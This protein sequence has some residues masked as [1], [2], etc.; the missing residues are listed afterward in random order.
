MK[1]QMVSIITPTCNSAKDIESCILSVARQSYP[2]KEHL[3]VDNLSSDNTLDIVKKYSAIY[4]HIRCI[5]ESDHGIYDAINKG[6]DR[7]RGEW[8]YFLG[9]DDTL[10]DNHVLMDIFTS[11]DFNHCEVIYG[12][13]Q[14]GKGGGTYDGE[15][16]L[17][18]LVDKN[19]CH[20]AIFFRRELLN[21]S[22]KFDTRYRILADWVF[23]MQWF[24]NTSVQRSYIDRTIAVYG[25]E[26]C[27]SLQRDELF[28]QEKEKLIRKYFPEEFV[29]QFYAHLAETLR[30]R[31]REIE[32]LHQALQGGKIQLRDLDHPL[33]Q[34][35]SLYLL[36]ITKPIRKLSNSLRKRLR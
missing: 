28:L 8:L 16:S 34:L 17:F 6:I 36:H 24:G 20:Q 22:G 26:G 10:F 27:S 14:W 21:R 30:E 25:T 35:F 2:N 7:S 19:I 4:P 13:V 29:D 11:P 5:T 9:S 1:N 18:K 31:E 12:N 32:R 33:S 23:N 3:I 15:F